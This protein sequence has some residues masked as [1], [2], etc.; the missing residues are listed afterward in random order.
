MFCM[1]LFEL[2]AIVWKLFQIL[3]ETMIMNM[4]MSFKLFRLILYHFIFC[5]M[6]ETESVGEIFHQGYSDVID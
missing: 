4:I 5:K 6:F 2:I 3:P 1:Y